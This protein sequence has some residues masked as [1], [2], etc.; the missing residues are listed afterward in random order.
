MRQ[1]QRQLPTS[2]HQ[3][4]RH[5][6]SPTPNQTSRTGAACPPPLAGAKTLA[7]SGEARR[8]A[9]RTDARRRGE[10]AEWKLE[11]VVGR[12]AARSV[13]EQR[14]EGCGTLRLDPR[15]S[16]D[17]RGAR[18]RS[19]SR[20]RPS[21]AATRA[22]AARRAAPSRPR[23]SAE[24]SS[25]PRRAGFARRRRSSRLR[26]WCVAVSGRCPVRGSGGARLRAAAARRLRDCR[27][28]RAPPRD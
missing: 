4:P 8:S 5:S 3:L 6:Q 27:R 15:R 26:P 17:R 9:S 24:A 7:S 19:S 14:A 23:G 12:A 25:A 18:T 16:R 10:L 13:P 21:P 22:R 11:V 1:E 20:R 28:R 2:R